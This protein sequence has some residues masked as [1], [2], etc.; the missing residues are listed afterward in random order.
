MIL[1]EQSENSK[2]DF[3]QLWAPSLPHTA[4]G[5]IP[6]P[7]QLIKVPGKIQPS[8]KRAM[9]LSTSHCSNELRGIGTCPALFLVY[10]FLLR[11]S[12]CWQ[13]VCVKREREGGREGKG[14]D[15]MSG[16]AGEFLCAKWSSCQ[17]KELQLKSW[18]RAF[19][20]DDIPNASERTKEKMERS[21]VQERRKAEGSP[22]RSRM[23]GELR[24]SSW[25]IPACRSL[26]PTSCPCPPG[27]CSR[28]RGVPKPLCWL[29]ALISTNRRK[30]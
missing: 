14:R 10:M 6:K 27:W 11:S 8:L 20:T 21:Q 18:H 25:H 3:S 12:L 17:Q 4:S 5:S 22:S 2:Q 7:L 15:F 28:N 30:I 16:L 29:Q 23:N 26:S 24:W 9:D 19:V 1:K 13:E